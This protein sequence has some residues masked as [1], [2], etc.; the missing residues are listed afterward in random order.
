MKLPEAIEAINS[1][2][3][4]VRNNPGKIWCLY[5]NML[6]IALQRHSIEDIKIVVEQLVGI[7]EDSP[8]FDPSGWDW[9][10]TQRIVSDEIIRLNDDIQKLIEDVD[11]LLYRNIEIEYFKNKWLKP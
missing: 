6:A 3:C 11:K 10:T 7:L 5:F 4:H 1:G 8:Y 2:L 9:E